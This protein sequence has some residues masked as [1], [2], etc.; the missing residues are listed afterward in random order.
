MGDQAS[1]FMAGTKLV[2]LIKFLQCTTLDL[3]SFN[4]VVDCTAYKYLNIC[5]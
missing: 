1:N 4:R 3:P 2:F 5:C